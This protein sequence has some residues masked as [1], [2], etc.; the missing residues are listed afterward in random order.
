MFSKR[1]KPSSDTIQDTELGTLSFADYGDTGSYSCRLTLAN[2]SK[3]VEV[4]FDTTSREYLPTEKQRQFL[5]SIV[6]NYDNLIEKAISII[7][8]TAA[9]SDLKEKTISKTQLQPVSLIIPQV[10]T[11]TF[12]WDMTFEV[13][14]LKNAFIIVYFDQFTPLSTMIEK[15]ERNPLTKFLLRLLNGHS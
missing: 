4:F 14:S 12:R 13:T 15:D 8:T 10:D 7:S 9:R 6:S 11:G 3:N 1:T 2:S 5:R